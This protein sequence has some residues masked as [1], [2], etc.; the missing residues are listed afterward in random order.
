MNSEL[1]VYKDNYLVEASYRLSLMEQRI[2]LFTIARLDPTNPKLNHEFYVRDFLSFFPDLDQRSIYNNLK[3][4]IDKLWDRSV[5]TEHPEYVQYFRWISSKK[6][7]KD[8][9]RISL[10][11]TPE[12]MP[13]LSQL[14]KQF[15]RYQLK[16]ISSFKG[17]YSIRLYELLTQ[18]KSTGNRGISIQDLRNWLQIGD[19]YPRYNSF[20]E[21][22]I[23]PSISEINQKS[24]L[25]ISVEPIK[26]GRKILALEF[27]INT[28]KAATTKK[29]R[30]PFP[31]KNKFG[32]VRFNAYDPKRSNHEWGEYARACLKVLEEHYN[33]CSLTEIDDQDLRHY[34]VFMLG[35]GVGSKV[36][37]RADII[38]ELKNR[39]Y[40]LVDSELV[41]IND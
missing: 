14:E 17:S 29:K 31:H 35:C 1:M 9:G 8:E 2:M 22:V 40:K 37:K 13:Y 12:I 10:S 19:K 18:Y 30:P 3:D 34:Y 28:R 33:G 32:N 11:F 16:N 7:Y 5:K 39:G 24:D 21:W 27:K 4:A 20:R 26:R 38:A 41:K 36:G 15:T 25:L 6:Y 23:E